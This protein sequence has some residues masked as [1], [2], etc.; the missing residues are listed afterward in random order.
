MAFDLLRRPIALWFLSDQDQRQPGLHR[1]GAAQQDG[2]KLRRR[3]TLRVLRN[4]LGEVFAQPAQQSRIRLEKELVE[5]PIGPPARAK[6]EIAFEVGGFHQVTS[7]LVQLECPGLHRP[8]L[9]DDVFALDGRPDAR[10]AASV[11]YK[12]LT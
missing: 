4:Q 8:N 6:N 7:E 9:A 2:P 5:I 10:G 1:N 12:H 11:S 3:E